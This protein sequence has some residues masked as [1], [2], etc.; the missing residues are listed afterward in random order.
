M[1]PPSSGSKNK[2]SLTSAFTLVSCSA[3]YSTPKTEAICFSKMLVDFQWI[4]QH[5]IPEDSTLHNIKL[6]MNCT[7]LP[8]TDLW[9]E[10]DRGLCA[11]INF[12]LLTVFTSYTLHNS[13]CES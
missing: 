1:S 13:G 7:A 4:A 5:Y 11:P 2:P 9:L 3:Y 10:R 8:H 6:F 12:Y